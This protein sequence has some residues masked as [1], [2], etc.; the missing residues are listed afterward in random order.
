VGISICAGIS[1]DAS[2]F[3]FDSVPFSQL[4]VPSTSAGTTRF[5]SHGRDK[6]AFFIRL[7]VSECGVRV[8][9][10][11]P[12]RATFARGMASYRVAEPMV[13]PVTTLHNSF[14]FKRIPICIMGP[15]TMV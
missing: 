9:D 10:S 14:V 12:I 8:I 4:I 15:T 13:T 2:G 6:P 11:R 1:A 7:G 3:T 5:R